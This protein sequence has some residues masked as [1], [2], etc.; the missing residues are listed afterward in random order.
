MRTR[1]EGFTLVETVASL[2]LLGILS[3][4][5]YGIMQVT[6]QMMRYSSRQAD[7]GQVTRAAVEHIKE[8]SRQE[9]GIPGCDGAGGGFELPHGYWATY[10]CSSGEEGIARLYK[11]DVHVRDA[12][13][14]GEVVASHSFFVTGGGY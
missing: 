13:P 11:V 4:I 6:D 5:A 12:S 8:W 7:V 9:L 3:V 14:L 1:D 2:A 10:D